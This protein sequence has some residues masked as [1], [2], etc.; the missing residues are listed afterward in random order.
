MSFVSAPRVVV[1]IPIE[2][3]IRMVPKKNFSTD[4]SWFYMHSSVWVAHE[5]SGAVHAGACRQGTH[6]RGQ[7][8]D[9]LDAYDNENDAG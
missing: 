4:R 7:A 1:S 2:A 6:M 8:T 3:L 9:I 5:T